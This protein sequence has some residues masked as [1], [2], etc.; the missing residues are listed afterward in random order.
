MSKKDEGLLKLL[1]KKA[2]ELSGEDKVQ[3]SEEDTREL[4]NIVYAAV[5]DGKKTGNNYL[6][7][8]LKFDIV[9][10]TAIIE[11]TQELEQKVIGMKF[12]LEQENLKYY[13]EKSKTAKEKK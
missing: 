6:L 12:P 13:Y 3:T 9:S 11:G 10:M 1:E 2:K 4:V 7:V 8:K 5:P